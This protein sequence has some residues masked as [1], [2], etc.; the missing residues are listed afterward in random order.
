MGVF[1][2]DEAELLSYDA[3]GFFYFAATMLLVVLLPWTWC[4]SSQVLWPRPPPDEDFLAA[5][6]MAK[7]SVVLCRTSAMEAK[8]SAA[9]KAARSWRS[10]LGGTRWL[11]VLAAAALWIILG[12][13]LWRLKDTAPQL[14]SFDPHKILGISPDAELREIKKAYRKKSLEH[15]PDKDRDNPLAPVLF[16]QVTKAYAALTDDA[17]RQNFAKYGN[18]DGPGQTKVGIALHPAMLVGKETQRVT[19][20]AFFSI[21]FLVPTLVLCCCLRGQRASA[22][23]VDAETLRVLHTC[24]DEEVRLEEAPSL[25]AASMEVRRNAKADLRLLVQVMNAEHPAP[26][27]AGVVVEVKPDAETAAEALRGKRGVVREYSEGATKCKVEV[28]DNDVREL[29]CASLKTL[30]PKLPRLFSDMIVRRGTALLY[31][32]MWRMH[33]RMGKAVQAEVDSALKNSIKVGRAMVSIAA[34]G[35]GDR[36]GYFEVVRDLVRFRQCLVQALDADSSPLLQLPHVQH[37]PEDAP[38]F[39]EVV[40]GGPALKTFL[41]QQKFNEQQVLDVEAFCRHVPQVEVSCSVGVSDEEG[42]ADGDLATLTV[43]LVRQNLEEGETVGAVHA[44][45]FP[46]AKYEE[47]WLLVYDDRGRRLV[48]VDVIL[49]TRNTEQS[50]LRF[51]VPRAGDFHWTVHAMCDSYVGLDVSCPVTFKALRKNQVK[52][53]IFIHPE[54][55]QIRTLFEELMEGLQ[56]ADDDSESEDEN[57]VKKP[58][59]DVAAVAAPTERPV[60][61]KSDEVAEVAKTDAERAPSDAGDSSDCDDD[62][63]E[64]AFFRVTSPTGCFLFREPREEESLRVGSL[65]CGAFVRGFEE[66]RPNGWAELA[67]GSGVWLRVEQRSSEEAPSVSSTSS[68]AKRLGTLC[69]QPLRTVVQTRTPLRMVRRWMRGASAAIEAEDILQVLGIEDLGVRMSVEEMLRRRVGDGRFEGLRDGAD[70][71]RLARKRRLSKALGFFSSHHGV[72]WHVLPSGAVRGLHSDGTKIRDRLE[73]TPEDAIKIGVFLLDETRHCSCIHWLHQDDSER[74][75]VWA[76]DTTLAT[77][78]RLGSAF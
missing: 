24:I 61:E 15:H 78:I 5:G 53:E 66:D 68:P 34:H 6:P 58:A 51:M 32:H 14:S 4:L 35:S 38:E 18:P 19:L 50:K 62:E 21:L 26:I 45:F 55:M 75:W 40:S 72:V 74:A 59:P 44:P 65:P 31:A 76:Q 1:T 2:R 48:T 47:W 28:G 42:I 49:G 23:G 43:T 71:L 73:V 13:V 29:P 39:K 11:Q 60:A 3:D 16:Q 25:F 64:G 57:E 36:S 7:G 8:H 10:R 52:R 77:R 12:L 27:Q 63:P 17:A 41:K 46:V 37:V 33:D 67:H 22:G 56:P 9:I 70:Q 30:E 20:V 69:E 54:D